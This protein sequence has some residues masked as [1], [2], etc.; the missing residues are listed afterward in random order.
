MEKRLFS[1]RPLIYRLLCIFF[2]CSEASFLCAQES[3]YAFISAPDSLEFADFEEESDESVGD[4]LTL[5]S[6][7]LSSPTDSL[8][9]LAASYNPP[10]DSIDALIFAFRPMLNHRYYV[11][12]VEIDT[13]LNRFHDVSNVVL[14]RYNVAAYLGN[15]GL[16]YYAPVYHMRE[17]PSDFMVTDHLRLY[18]HNPEEIDHFC[19]RKPY[20]LLQYSLAGGSGKEEVRMHIT[21]TQ[22]VNERVNLGLLFDSNAADGQYAHQA[23]GDNAFSVFGSYRGAR[24]QL[25]GSIGLNKIKMKENGGLTDLEN[26]YTTQRRTDVYDT[27]SNSGQTVLNET[28]FFVA[29]SYAF[30]NKHLVRVDTIFSYPPD[31]LIATI[32][33]TLSTADSLRMIESM[34]E[35]DFDSIYNTNI[36]RFNVVHTMTYMSGR[37]KFDDKLQDQPSLYPEPLLTP[38]TADRL[39]YGRLQNTLELMLQEKQRSRLT[40]GF[41]AGLLN[42]IDRYEYDI[43]PDSVFTEND[44]TVHTRRSFSHVNTAVTGRFFNHTGH[45]LNWDIGAKLFFTGYKAGSLEIDGDVRFYTYTP[46]GRNVLSLGA[47]LSNEKPGYF[48]EA[49]SSNHFIWDNHFDDA[50]HVRLR[51]EFE[52]PHRG[53]KAGFYTSQINKLI[54]F[55]E[56]A[57]PA[58]TSEV[59]VTASGAV[60]KHVRA[61]KFHFLFNLYGQYSSEEDILPLPLFTGLQSTYFETWVVPGVL[62]MQLGYDVRYFTP[63]YAYAYMPATGVFYLQHESKVGNYPFVNAFVDFKLKRMHISVTGESLTSLL[64]GTI[65]KKYF[66]VYRYP[67]NEAR[68]KVGLSWAFYD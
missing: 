43:Q 36:S 53:L 66:T 62:Q 35:M 55:D 10:L 24:Y 41:S 51:A 31:S 19:T 26:F 52:N 22:N 64:N 5:S 45:K 21:H 14:H 32:S 44:T 2:V 57:R 50:Q 54:Y 34:I 37:R 15:L 60:E 40:A 46:H 3:D 20:T 47:T 33:D 59:V 65:D 49:Y 12:R 7:I 13:T 56:T 30:T 25:Y 28:D 9:R 23:T 4:S 6:G 38:V 48:M 39:K 68:I 17:A 27:Y 63:Y 11:H 1:L 29:Q 42:M 61:G 18:M 16:S 8:R 58:Q 67:L